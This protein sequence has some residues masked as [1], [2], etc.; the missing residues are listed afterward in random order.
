[1]QSPNR[2]GVSQILPLPSSKSSRFPFA[3]FVLP[4]EMVV[5]LCVE[6]ERD[7]NP[8]QLLLPLG[9]TDIPRHQKLWL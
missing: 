6:M 4:K 2:F 9:A 8:K 1:V 3:N 7:M 5:Y